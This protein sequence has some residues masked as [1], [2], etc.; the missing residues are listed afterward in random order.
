M[1]RLAFLWFELHAAR[2]YILETFVESH[3]MQFFTPETK[4]FGLDLVNNCSARESAR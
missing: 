4:E 3:V 2:Q 1:Q